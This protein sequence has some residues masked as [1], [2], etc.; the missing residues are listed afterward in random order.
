ML[1]P[2]V[3]GGIIKRGGIYLRVSTNGQTTENQCRELEAVAARSGW[4]V[5]GVYEDAGTFIVLTR[6]RSHSHDWVLSAIA[7]RWPVLAVDEYQDLGLP[8]HRIVKRLAFDGG[9]R[10][11]AVG[12]PRPV[13]LWF[14]VSGHGHQKLRGERS[15]GM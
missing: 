15:G 14:S 13:G 11:F 10:L 9:V 8:L 4:E 7:G 6:D 12:D 1:G 3:G 5:I 2:G